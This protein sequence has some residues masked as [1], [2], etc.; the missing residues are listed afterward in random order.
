[1]TLAP[2]AATWVDRLG[3]RIGRTGTSLC[4]GIDPDPRSLP[5]GLP[6]DVNG[7]E[8]FA[9][10]LL[11]AA[12]PVAAA[13][14]VNIAYFE[15]WGSRGIAAL[16]RLRERVPDDLPLILDA[17]RGDIGS[18]SEQHARA[19]FDRLGASAVTASPYLGPDAIAP[20]LDRPDRFVYL[21]CRTSNPGAGELQA[22]EV[23]SDPARGLPA[24]PLAHRVA[25]L[26][27]GWQRHPE[28][29]GLVVGATAPDEL[30]AIRSIAPELP[31]LVPGVGSQGGDVESALSAGRAT[32]GPAG[33]AP[34]GGLL[35]NV[36]RSIA[37][38]ARGS[39][40]PADA[41][42]AAASGWARTLQVLR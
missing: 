40:D 10:L 12:I 29:V 30:A 6:A 39:S 18:T 7:I 3:I 34:G 38:A 35:V 2:V 13:I 28:T 20:L 16:E 42:A 17:K 8:R 26:A 19:I 31:F 9:G 1:V 21:L 25:R 22:L 27:G 37:D 23:A 32:S 41:L 33:R 4:L 11:D 15:A 36:S 14:K 24:E 5:T